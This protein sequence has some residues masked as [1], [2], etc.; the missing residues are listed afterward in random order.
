MVWLESVSIG[1]AE[2]VSELLG[3]VVDV[4]AEGLDGEIKATV[5]S[6]ING[7]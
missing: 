3:D 1:L 5:D 7:G 4:V 6:T 2:G